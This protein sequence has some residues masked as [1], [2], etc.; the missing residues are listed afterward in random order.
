M[1]AREYCDMTKPKI[2]F[3]P[4]ILSHHMLAGLKEGQAK[5]SKSDP[6]ECCVTIV[7]TTSTAG[8]CSFLFLRNRK[9]GRGVD[10]FD[11]AF[12]ASRSTAMVYG[13]DQFDPAS[14]DFPFERALN[15]VSMN[16][17]R[18]ASG[19]GEYCDIVSPISGSLTELCVSA[20]FSHVLGCRRH[21][22]LS[23]T[24]SCRLLLFLVSAD[25]NCLYLDCSFAAV[26]DDLPGASTEVVLRSVDQ[27]T[28]I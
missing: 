10:S 4:V 16:A 24:D 1:L 21:R 5:M 19:A 2:K 11:A 17:Y 23:S 6:G 12:L 13:V 9:D 26:A 14:L 3:K 7:V 22:R 8:R 25:V 27:N 18:V 15:A 20:R 28:W